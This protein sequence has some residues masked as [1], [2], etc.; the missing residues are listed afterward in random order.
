MKLFA[1]YVGGEAPGANIELHDMRFIVAPSIE[2]TYDALHRQW[3]GTPGKLHIDCWAEID[4]ADGYDVSLR[5][6]P[7]EGAKK[8]FY[9]NLGG[10]DR[11]QFSELHRNVFVVAESLAEAKARALATISGWMEPHR[12]DIYEADQAFALDSQIEEARLHIHLT[13]AAETRTIAFTC[14]YT[15]LGAA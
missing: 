12:D 2:Q 10:Y 3:W 15:P 11:N 8:L 1:V 4:H 9:V 13:P 6:E 14:K 7:A 5:P